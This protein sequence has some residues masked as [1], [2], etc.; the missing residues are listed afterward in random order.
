VAEVV[1]QEWG[2]GLIR[3][4]NSAGWFDA[5]RRAGDKIARLVGAGPNEV[6]ATD[7]TS[8]NLFKVLSAALN[9]ARDA[10]APQRKTLVSE[11]SN[12]PTDL[13]IAE[14]LC[15]ERGFTLKLVEPDEIADSLSA[16]VAVLMLTHVNYRTGAMHDMAAVTRV[17][18]T[19]PASSR[20]GIWHTAQAPCR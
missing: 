15:R 5:P 1:T 20:S 12:F 19:P 13:Y 3:S 8:I 14:A 4:W 9:M 17:R 10:D 2:Q 18:R 16:D 7:S 6:V 11:R